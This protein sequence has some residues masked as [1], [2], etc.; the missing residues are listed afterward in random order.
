MSSSSPQSLNSIL[1]AFFTSFQGSA[2]ISCSLLSKNSSQII[3]FEAFSPF[4]HFI[5][6]LLT[7][8][9]SS[10]LPKTY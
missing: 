6:T 10:N 3:D 9:T 1:Q 7:Q 8:D 5:F 4:F 2:W